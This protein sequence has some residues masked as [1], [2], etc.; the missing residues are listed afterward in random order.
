MSKKEKA[1]I[2][3]SGGHAMLLTEIIRLNGTCEIIGLLDCDKNTHGKVIDGFTVIGGDDMLEELKSECECAFIG[4][5][6]IK[7]GSCIIREKIFNNL[8]KLGYK[9]PSLIH[10][11]ALL[12]D[13]ASIAEGCQI[14]AGAI[15][16][17]GAVLSENVILN[18]GTIVEHHCRIGQSSALGS[19]AVLCGGVTIGERSHIGAGA[20]VI[21]RLE[22]GNDTTAGAGTV[23]VR[24]L[25]NGVKAVGVPAK[26]K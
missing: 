10:P 20:T 5:G 19:G 4:L 14:M 21:Q 16:Q 23:V 12:S 3:G 24:N 8:K 1:L 11:A 26:I 2:V 7:S 25:P 22:I 13:T 17:T 15:V 9:T 18:A 6:S